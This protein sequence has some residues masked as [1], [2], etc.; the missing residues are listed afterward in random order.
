MNCLVCNKPLDNNRQKRFCSKVCQYAGFSGSLNPMFK[1]AK[2]RSTCKT[3]GKQFEYYKGSSSGIYC[4]KSCSDICSE[5]IEKMI[6][7]K[8]SSFLGKKDSVIKARIRSGK[9]YLLWVKNVLKRDNYKCVLC[10]SRKEKQVHHLTPFSV[11]YQEVKMTGF[12]NIDWFYDLGNGQTLCKGC[13]EQTAS[14]FNNSFPE[15]KLIKTMNGAFN[16]APEGY[17]TFPAYYENKMEE[18]IN[19]FK[20]KLD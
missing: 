5:R 11:I 8:T 6:A 19:H 17:K 9:R 12:K 16:K 3:C 10:G 2:Q 18:L 20:G 7:A 4:S 14:H 13:H 1:A 15:L